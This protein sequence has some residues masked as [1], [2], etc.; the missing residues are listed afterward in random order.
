M[1]FSQRRERVVLFLTLVFFFTTSLLFYE[2]YNK[3]I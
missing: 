1:A 3:N 2:N